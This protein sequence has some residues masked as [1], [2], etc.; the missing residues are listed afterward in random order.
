MPFTPRA[1]GK[2]GKARAAFPAL[3]RAPARGKA[4]MQPGPLGRGPLVLRRGKA[5]GRQG[6]RPR[7]QRWGTNRGLPR[8]P[9]SPTPSIGGPS[10]TAQELGRSA[11]CTRSPVEG[12]TARRPGAVAGRTAR[13]PVGGKRSMTRVRVA[14]RGPRPRGGVKPFAVA[15]FPLPSEP[16]QSTGKAR[17]RQ[18][19][20]PAGGTFS[21]TAGKAGV[22]AP[23]PGRLPF[24]QTAGKPRL[25]EAAGQGGR[26]SMGN[27]VLR[28]VLDIV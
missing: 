21:R 17:H 25:V 22:A 16:L 10:Q 23:W 9:L 5:R 2:T 14:S 13:S 1:T 3:A 27:P 11:G 26:P 15:A 20:E 8:E 24:P 7:P 28:K 12:E 6:R 19:R 4:A 18:S